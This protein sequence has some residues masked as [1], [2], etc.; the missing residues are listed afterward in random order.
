MKKLMIS[1]FAAGLLAVGSSPTTAGG[2]EECI[3]LSPERGAFEVAPDA[4]TLQ[5]ETQTHIIGPAAQIDVYME[6]MD[7]KGRTLLIPFARKMYLFPTADGRFV[8]RIKD[9]PPDQ[10]W[11][12]PF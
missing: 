8:A 7:H 3:Q 12:G 11:Y 1:M 5:R 2:R 10:N 9:F 4:V 6:H